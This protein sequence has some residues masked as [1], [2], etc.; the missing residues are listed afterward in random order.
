MGG[1]VDQRDNRSALTFLKKYFPPLANETVFLIA[2]QAAWTAVIV[3][4]VEEAPFD[5]SGVLAV[6]TGTLSFILPLQLN[7][8][9]RKNRECLKAYNMFCND[10]LAL[11]WYCV[12][13]VPKGKMKAKENALTNIFNI[14]AALPATVKHQFRKDL[15][16]E[17][18]KGVKTT[19]GVQNILPGNELEKATNNSMGPVNYVYLKL[20]DYIN[21]FA[22]NENNTDTALQRELLGR[23][24][25]FHGHWGAL[26]ALVTYSPPMIF[27]SVLNLALLFW[28]VLLPLPLIGV[29]N[30][31]VWM[32]F[33]TSYFFLGLNL[34]GRKIGNAFAEGVVGF[35]T[36]TTRQK[37]T[38]AAIKDVWEKRDGIAGSDKQLNPLNQLNFGASQFFM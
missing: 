28:S 13:I 23:F 37:R 32:V 22:K 27:T 8:A 31:A 2:A 34:S 26:D 1:V 18:A 35:G 7:S 10:V 6:L 16:L 24:S 9:L 38:T 29:G 5:A 14:L 20:V 33:I 36:V 15:N 17:Q 3:N 21:D 4:T 12:A 19:L 30:N 25:R 11:A